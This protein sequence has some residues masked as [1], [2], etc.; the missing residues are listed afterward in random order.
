MLSGW[1]LSGTSIVQ[2]GTPF[3]V[4]TT[5][6]FQPVRNANGV[7][8]GFQPGSGDYNADGFNRDFP[9]V[10]DYSMNSSRQ[11]FLNGAFKSGQFTQPA[12][13]SGGNE[14]VSRFRNPAYN[15]TD[16]ALLKNTKI[17]ERLNL[18]L[19]FEAYNVF[20]Q[21]NLRELQFRSFECKLRKVHATV[22]SAELCK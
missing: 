13:G 19:R 22:Q 8:T 20:N 10:G 12:F 11:G 1:S 7:F 18:Q 17:F 5:A 16:A 4:F 3:T 9:N 21:V 2:S 14:T 6:T 15:Q